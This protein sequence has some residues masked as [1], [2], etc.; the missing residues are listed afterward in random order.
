MAIL[1]TPAAW[2][3]RL[4]LALLFGLLLLPALQAQW[5]LLPIRP[6]DGATNEVLAPRFSW[7]KVLSGSYQPTF[8]AYLTEQLGCRPWLVRVRNQLAFSLWHRGLAEGV[9]PGKD[10]NLYQQNSINTYLGRNYIGEAD[11]SKRARHLRR[12][13]DSLQ[14]HGTQ[15]LFVIAPSKARILPQYLPDSCRNSPHQGPISNY[16]MVSQQFAK[17]GVHTLDAAALLLRW[18]AAHPP[19]PL[20]T[21]TG[22]HWS[23]YATVRVADTLFRRVEQLTGRDLPDFAQQGP[24]TV[25]TN[26]ADLRHSDRDLEDLL[27]LM[28]GITPYPTAYPNVVFRPA[29]GPQQRLNALLIGDSFTKSFYEFYPYFDQLLTPTSRFWYYNRTVYWPLKTPPSENRQVKSLNLAA[30][31][32][33]RQLVLLLAMEGNLDDPGFGF[34][35][36]AFDLYCPISAQDESGIQKIMHNIAHNPEWLAS[37]AKGA[38]EHK[39]S[40]EQ[41][42]R[43][44]AK[45][46]YDQER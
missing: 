29:R 11:I 5:P 13:Q 6:L 26:S 42:I 2:A 25:V 45:Y 33:G 28:Q 17:Y 39:I 31:L 35:G 18:Q 9:V 38:A 23:G 46:L 44:N 36:E 1:S 10:G 14:A 27:N 21:R 41:A 37:V 30:Q 3:K 8:E 22:T 12:V 4:L 7:R 15:L 43:Q 20:F 40:V 34:I 24:P 19:Y 16:A 32:K